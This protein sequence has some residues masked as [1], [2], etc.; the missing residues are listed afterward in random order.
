MQPNTHTQQLSINHNTE[1]KQLQIQIQGKPRQGNSSQGYCNTDDSLSVLPPPRSTRTVSNHAIECT[2]LHPSI[3]IE[4]VV[5]WFVENLLLSMGTSCSKFDRDIWGCC[6]AL[7]GF[8]LSV[9]LQLLCL[10]IVVEFH[11]VAVCV[12]VHWA[13]L[14]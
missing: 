7:L 13:A 4:S 2:I 14:H 11:F 12:C 1:A 10:S 3:G 5:E 6:V 9:N 8:A